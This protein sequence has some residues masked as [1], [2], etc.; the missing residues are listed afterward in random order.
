MIKENY[1]FFDIDAKN[2]EEALDFI[3][4]KAFEYGIT[5]DKDGLLGD[6][7]KREEEYSTGLQDEF[8]IPHA[9]SIHAKEVAIFFVKCKNELDWETLDD[10]KVKYLFAL[11][12]PMENAGNEHLLMISKLATSLLEDEFKDK[13]KS[14]TDKA[15]LKEYILKIMKEDN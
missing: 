12:V 9:K 8:A 2:K 15:E 11:I 7:L 1:I 13:V 6:F 4:S 3:S 14:S 10:S 5:D